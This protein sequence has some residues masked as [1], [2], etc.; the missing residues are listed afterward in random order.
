MRKVRYQHVDD[1]GYFTFHLADGSAV[2]V[3]SK[4]YATDDPGQIAVLDACPFV[5]RAKP[6]K[7]DG[8]GEE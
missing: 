8:G 1:D 4:G 6:S 5:K 3:S 7:D 2:T